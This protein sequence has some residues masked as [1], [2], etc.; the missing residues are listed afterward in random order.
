MTRLCT[1]VY[2]VVKGKDSGTPTRPGRNPGVCDQDCRGTLCRQVVDNLRV[3][4]GSYCHGGHP[5]FFSGPEPSVS[6]PP[7]PTS[8]LL[9]ESDLTL[10]LS[11]NGTPPLKTSGTTVPEIPDLTSP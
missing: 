2:Y 6:V 7:P 9:G 5:Q 8:S 4:L 11:S 10:S 1:L 3:L